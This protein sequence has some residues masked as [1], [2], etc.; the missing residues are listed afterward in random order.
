MD[1]L[2]SV[3]RLF[4]LYS[5]FIIIAYLIS[6]KTGK[7]NFKTYIRLVIV[8]LVWEIFSKLLLGD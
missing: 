7:E 6:L 1:I 8:F 5:L 4:F 3:L 2:D